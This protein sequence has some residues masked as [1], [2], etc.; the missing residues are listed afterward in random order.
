MRGTLFPKQNVNLKAQ[1][2]RPENNLKDHFPAQV[3]RNYKARII[4]LYHNYPF[5]CIESRKELRISTKAV[6]I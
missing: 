4:I 2:N 3:E 5:E 1:P 6:C